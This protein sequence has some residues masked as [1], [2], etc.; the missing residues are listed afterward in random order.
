MTVP[1]G[2]G[3]LSMLHGTVKLT[4]FNVAVACSCV[5]PVSFW[6]SVLLQV[7]DDTMMLTGVLSQLLC[8]LSGFGLI[9]PFSMEALLISVICPQ[10]G[11]ACG[12]SFVA[13]G[14]ICVTTFGNGH[15]RRLFHF[16]NDEQT[17]F[18]WRGEGR[19]S[20]LLRLRRYAA[21]FSFFHRVG[22]AVLVMAANGVDDKP[23]R[24]Q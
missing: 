6:Y 21:V 4:A 12:E 1:A 10:S 13:S 15:F 8:L 7:L 14:T 16:H 20:L 11:V 22:A 2:Q 24:V 19:Q 5:K 3:R 23:V 18:P 9:V 17:R